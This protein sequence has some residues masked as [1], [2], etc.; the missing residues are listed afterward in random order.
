[1]NFVF[2]NRIA[3]LA[4]ATLHAMPIKTKAKKISSCSFNHTEQNFMIRKR[5]STGMV[6]KRWPYL[7]KRIAKRQSTNH[8][9]LR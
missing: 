6:W 7:S 1:M 5:T 9:Q 4:R 8:P 3:W 2:F